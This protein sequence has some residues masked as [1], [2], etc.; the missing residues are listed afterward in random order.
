MPLIKTRFIPQRFFAHLPGRFTAC[1]LLACLSASGYAANYTWDGTVGDWN[2]PTSWSTDLVPTADDSAYINNSGTAT[3]PVGVSGTYA[4]LYLGRDSS[5]GSS[6]HVLINGGN[7]TGIIAFIG[8]SGGR[9]SITVN[10]GTLNSERIVV[11]ALGGGSLMV[12]GGHVIS[13]LRVT[14]G[15]SVGSSGTATITN[16]TLATQGDLIIGN[17]G[18][19]QIRVGSGGSLSVS[20]STVIGI[21]GSGTLSVDGGSF[22]TGNLMLGQTA[23][24]G[25]LLIN[26]ASVSSHT[27]TLGGFGSSSVTITSGTWD[28]TGGIFVS[29]SNGTSSLNITDS[30]VNSG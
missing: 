22:S 30:L 7:L 13:S 11:G 6:G 14:V 4:G 2:A 1:L 5:S 18:T 25:T 28:N 26:N 27:A 19:G 17:S 12:D 3:L 16:G 20:G 23:G 21:F 24:R 10:S 8:G 29:S 15:D 9:G